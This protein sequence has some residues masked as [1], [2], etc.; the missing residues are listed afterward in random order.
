[1]NGKNINDLKGSYVFTYIFESTIS[2]FY[3]LDL[4]G[5]KRLA[6]KYDKE[7]S[8]F[9]EMPRASIKYEEKEIYDDYSTIYLGNLENMES[10]F[11]FIFRYF[12]AKRQQYQKI[13]VEN[14]NQNDFQ[15]EDFLCIKQAF[16]KSPITERAT[17]KP[18]KNGLVGYLLNYNKVDALLFT[19][20][21]LAQIIGMIDP[22]R[23]YKNTSFVG[24]YKAL[25]SLNGLKKTED[26]IMGFMARLL[27]DE[28]Y[29]NRLISRYQKNYS[30]ICDEIEFLENITNKMIRNEPND[31]KR[32]ALLCLHEDVWKNLNPLQRMIAISTCNEFI[33]EVLRC[34][35]SYSVEFKDGENSFDFEDIDCIFVGDPTKKSPYEILRTLI[36]AQAFNKNKENIQSLSDE[37]REEMLDEYLLCEEKFKESKSHSDIK[38]YH[39]VK[40]VRK[41]ADELLR[42]SYKYISNNLRIGGKKIPV[43]ITKEE[44]TRDMYEERKVRR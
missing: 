14:N 26:K 7:F 31:D 2:D 16:E 34:E 6:E 19:Y 36:Y 43:K 27:E 1:M 22:D 13:C 32:Y 41:T 44:F 4:D 3:N 30:F 33:E 35:K 23:T 28:R 12:F 5:K 29:R 10:G 25:K 9:F 8:E 21:Q 11:E 40:C 18:Y 15:D 38:D 24:Q 20:E 37:G 17:Y 42:N 39:F